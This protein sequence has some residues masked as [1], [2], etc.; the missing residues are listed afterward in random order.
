MDIAFRINDYRKYFIFAVASLALLMSSIDSTIVATALPSIEKSLGAG[1][2]WTGW[3]ITVYQ[4]T[5][6]TMM[7]LMGRISD[8]WGR[9]RVFLACVIIFTGSSL[10][11]ALS[12]N[13]YMLIFSRFLQAMGGGSLMPSAVGIVGDNFKEHRARAIGLF[14]SIFPLGGIIGP[15]LGGFLLNAYSWKSIFLVNLPIGVVLIILAYVLLDKDSVATRTKVD[16]IGAGL[17]AAMI[18]SIMYFMTR[19]GE[20]PEIAAKL[21]NYLLP[22]LS[23]VF[24]LLFLRREK[25]TTTPILDLALLRNKSFAA[26]NLL[27]IIYGTCVFGIAAFIPYYAQVV[28]GMSNLAS[29]ALLSVR[30][31]GMMGTA[32]IT[33]MLLE[34]TGYRLPIAL[35]FLAFAL[36]TIG[37]IPFFHVSQIMGIAISDHWWLGILVFVS[38]VGVGLAG[39]PSNNAAIELM[40]DKIS[41]ISGLRGMFRQTGGVFGASFIVLVLSRNPD[42]T[43]GFSF[44]FLCISVLLI[45][46]LLLVKEV[47]DGL[48]AARRRQ[49]KM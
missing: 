6:M 49:E 39:P 41:A 24:L 43:A 15:A 25:R 7:P 33:S 27:N 14:T 22:V 17:F 30:A 40:P 19:L 29:G 28:Y 48:S 11:C 13:I 4:L 34:R 8:E 18:I 10:M 1:L 36:S 2:N 44:A 31:V 9:K 26:I 23:V 16:F 32:A 38:G 3:V 5:M 37:L 21:N 45:L 42:K 12:T 20:G 35:G 46:A 47:P